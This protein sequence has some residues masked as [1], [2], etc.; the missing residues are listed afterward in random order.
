MILDIDVGNSAIKWR[1]FDQGTTLLRG[2][3]SHREEDWS[4]LLDHQ[5]DLERARVSNVAGANLSE[6]LTRWLQDN[7]GVMAEFA[8]SQARTAGVVSGYQAPE[9]LGVDRWL[10][11]VASW[12][13][14]KGSCLVVDA[15]SALTIDFVGAKGKHQGGYIVPGSYM[16]FDALYG[17]TAGGTGN[18][19]FRPDT[20]CT[21]SPGKNTAEAV[22]NGCFTMSVALIEKSLGRLQ[23][24]GDVATI[25]LT[26]GGSASLIKRLDQKQLRHI[27]DL[28]LDGLEYALP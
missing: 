24:T 22:Q 15:G 28:V 2:A 20:S 5:F 21:Q 11:V 16:M 19:R 25:V 27:P 8:V 10:A 17:G 3:V 6:N 4:P 9:T 13:M 1:V 18:A 23:Q 7:A 14:I 12:N 26:G